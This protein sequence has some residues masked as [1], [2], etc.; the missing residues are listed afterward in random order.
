MS[1]KKLERFMHKTA[2]A[3]SAMSAPEIVNHARWW[4]LMHKVFR[5]SGAEA[6]RYFT[7]SGFL[8]DRQSNELDSSEFKSYVQKMKFAVTGG[9][10][11]Q[12]Y[13][14]VLY[15]LMSTGGLT[16]VRN[17]LLHLKRNYA[18]CRLTPS[19]VPL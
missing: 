19:S 2:R 3:T 16:R 18:S 11:S 10:S 8:A 15:I 4:S 6:K 13:E 17:I 9:W 5:L 7:P 12:R 14:Y 1:R